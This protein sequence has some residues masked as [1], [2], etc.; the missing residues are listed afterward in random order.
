MHQKWHWSLLREPLWIFTQFCLSMIAIT[1]A[2]TCKIFSKLI[3]IFQERE[4]TDWTLL[5]VASSSEIFLGS[6][7][8]IPVQNACFVFGVDLFKCKCP[9]L[10]SLTIFRLDYMQMKA[11][12]NAVFS[13]CFYFRWAILLSCLAPNYYNSSSVFLSRTNNILLYLR[14]GTNSHDLVILSE[15]TNSIDMVD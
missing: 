6:F 10:F 4:E 11:I 2:A 7:A 3:I 15:N 9:C 5:C 12:I 14:E 1:R 8:N 13:F